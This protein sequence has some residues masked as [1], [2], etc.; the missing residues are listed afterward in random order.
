M[1]QSRRAKIKLF[2]LGD[3]KK[4]VYM[5]RKPYLTIYQA[6]I[7]KSLFV[8]KTILNL[9]FN[10]NTNSDSFITP[11]PDPQHSLDTQ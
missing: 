3:F 10:N 6:N 4:I 9:T 2:K 1:Q 7:N 11:G 5:D 8:H